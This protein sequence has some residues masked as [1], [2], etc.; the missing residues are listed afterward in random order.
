MP[1]GECCFGP[2]AGAPRPW[3]R[4]AV[5]DRE[6]SRHPER[7]QI[8]PATSHIFRAAYDVACVMDQV[9]SSA[10]ETLRL[11]FGARRPASGTDTFA[12]LL[13]EPSLLVGELIAEELAHCGFA[14]LRPALLAVGAHL[15]TAGSG[16]PSSPSGH[17]SP[18]PPWCTPW[19]SSSAWATPVGSPTPST[20]ARSSSSPPSARSPPSVPR[21]T[22]SPRSTPPGRSCSATARCSSSNA[23][24]AACAPR[25][26]PPTSAPF[27][28]SRQR[29][30]GTWSGRAGARRPYGAV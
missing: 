5:L 15:R 8:G 10:E 6:V 27:G 7:R 23:R 1:H 28:P 25:C 20:G 11:R 14:D 18:R 12:D 17:S 9:G 19:T 21:A 4:A 13:R 29:L 3:E 2:D 16:A 22:P 24:C 26:G 30:R